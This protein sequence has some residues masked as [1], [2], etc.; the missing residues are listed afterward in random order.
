MPRTFYRRLPILLFLFLMV[1]TANTALAA[2]AFQYIRIGDVDGFGFRDPGGLMRAFR[3]VGPGPAD[4]DGDGLLG[5]GE[6]LPDLN[7]DGGVAWM[8]ADNFDNRGFEEATNRARVCVGC[9]S[10]GSRTNG[11]VWTDLSLSASAR[12]PNWPD[13]DGPQPP[14]NARFVFDFTISRDT[15]PEGVQIFFNLVFGDY[16][17]DPALVGVGF[18]NGQTRTLQISNQGPLDGL[19]QART[20]VFAF[21]EVFTANADDDWHG[22]VNVVFLAPS[23]PYTAFDFVELSLVELVTS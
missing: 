17:I 16:D 6:F 3:S 4:S 21:D 14:N 1:P 23:D 5:E 22:F 8:S 19:I 7:G 10:I 2:E 9:L 11:A 13:E 18:A 20:A 15:I 12:Y